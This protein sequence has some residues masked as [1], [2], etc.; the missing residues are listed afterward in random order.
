MGGSFEFDCTNCLPGVEFLVG[1]LGF[2][3]CVGWLTWWCLVLILGGGP[4]LFG[5]FVVLGA[6]VLGV[7]P[8]I[9]IQMSFPNFCRFRLKGPGW[10]DMGERGKDWW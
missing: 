9:G 2:L 10:E 4:G 1:V 7:V 5:W 3:G 6:L 8:E